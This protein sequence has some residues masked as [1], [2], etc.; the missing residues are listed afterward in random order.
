MNFDF[1]HLGIFH[2]RGQS[3]MRSVRLTIISLAVVGLAFGVYQL[4]VDPVDDEELTTTE[5]PEIHQ[6]WLTEGRGSGPSNE[7]VRF[8]NVPEVVMVD[9]G[10]TIYEQDTLRKRI[11]MT[12]DNPRQVD[13]SGKLFHVRSPIITYY[14][15]RG[16][17]AVIRADEALITSR[18]TR[19]IDPQRGEFKGNVRIDVDRRTDKWRQDNPDLA[20]R[21]P[22]QELLA[23]MW[24]DT[25]TFDLDLGRLQAHGFVRI[26]A[27]EML[28]EGE[29]LTVHWSEVSGRVEHLKLKSGKQLVF[30]GDFG[31]GA[32]LTE[33]EQKTGPQPPDQ[34]DNRQRANPEVA[35]SA[36]PI[37]AAA[38]TEGGQASVGDDDDVLIVDLPDEDLTSRQR[39][40]TYE[41][42]FAS[43]VLATESGGSKGR[44]QADHLSILFDL[45]T[46]GAADRERDPRQD[47]QSS[48]LG[49]DETESVSDYAPRRKTTVTWSGPLE[50]RAVAET[51]NATAALRRHLRATGSPV[52]LENDDLRATSAELLY[53]QETK[54]IHFQADDRFPVDLHGG[55]GARFFARESIV[56]DMENL[57]ANLRGDVRVVLDDAELQGQVIDA[58]F[59]SPSPGSDSRQPR[60]LLD[61][62]VCEQD[63]RFR[64]AA[65]EMSCGYLKL[66][67]ALDAEGR[68]IPR[69]AHATEDVSIIQ[70]DRS[71]FARERMDVTFGDLPTDDQGRAGEA[72]SLP[73]RGRRAPVVREV[74]AE[75][76]VQILDPTQTW[77][78]SGEI[79]RCEFD[80]QQAITSGYIEGPAGQNAKVQLGAYYVEGRTVTFD[81][82]RPWAHVPGPGVARFVLTEDLDGRR[83]GEPVPVEIRWDN[84][85]SLRGDEDVLEFDGNVVA[86]SEDVTLTSSR[87]MVALA[88]VQPEP[89][90]EVAST[91]P[92]GFWFLGPFDAEVRQFNSLLGHEPKRRGSVGGRIKKRAKYI[93]ADGNASLVS[94]TQSI[95][96]RLQSLISLQAEQI[97]FDL[98]SQVMIVEHPGR[99]GIQDYPSPDEV[100]LAGRRSGSGGLFSNLQSAGP[101]QTLIR[102]DSAMRYYFAQRVAQFTGG[103]EPV[104]LRHLSGAYIAM[105]EQLRQELQISEDQLGNL[106]AAG[107]GRQTDLYCQQLLVEFERSRGRGGRGAGQMSLGELRQFQASGDVVLRDPE[108]NVTGERLDFV[109][110]AQLISVYGFQGQDAF[111]NFL[112]RRTGRYVEVKCPELHVE[113]KTGFVDAPNCDTITGGR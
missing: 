34:P 92:M 20:D 58:Y 64:T 4:G 21:P 5:V 27:Q 36:P 47:P 104:L 59:R 80:D 16:Q 72:G 41:I 82:T 67:F 74:Y 81:D 103:S 19:R 42:D 93:L 106:R 62:L 53:H 96:G 18:E 71:L 11:H 22:P 99:L 100:A 66:R 97:G 48:G 15:K 63:V 91:D 50:I 89:D 85:M 44:L 25:M 108:W 86:K 110:D 69:Q 70:G 94:R 113:M 6:K 14:V 101:S 37:A 102:W 111:I 49:P 2:R 88:D 84:E 17:K 12:F 95:T 57:T 76:D 8:G 38:R 54:F 105:N 98:D 52:V 75:G 87:L 3:L 90:I 28:L 65:E 30:R 46:G 10:I 112:D 39:V 23:R 40:I 33:R 32:S 73:L 35:Q 78:I 77:D 51:D 61:E 109:D 13:S 60:D 56:W 7:G 26:E 68:N 83:T 55:N 1:A 43:D 9:P 79:L 31:L 107:R 29:G 24:M 45:P